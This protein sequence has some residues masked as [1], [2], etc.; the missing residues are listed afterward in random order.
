[1]GPQARQQHS[2][3]SYA[4]P[5]FNVPRPC[6]NAAVVAVHK[7]GTAPVVL[8]LAAA[9]LAE[10]AAEQL[11][12]VSAALPVPRLLCMVGAPRHAFKTKAP[13][14]ADLPTKIC[15]TCNRPFTWRKKWEAV[16]D[17]V[18]C[19][20]LGLPS[21]GCLS[22]IVLR[23]GEQRVTPS[24]RYCSERCRRARKPANEKEP[25]QESD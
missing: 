24:C 11:M 2:P 8:W 16:W 7:Q 25:S 9:M 21:P 10:D 12:L 5:P 4:L 1:M 23:Q 22:R 14:K 13:N 3:E 15:K 19:A 17:D 20:V 6:T 18:K